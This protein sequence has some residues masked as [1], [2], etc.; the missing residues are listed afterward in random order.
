MN[1][2]QTRPAVLSGG[3]RNGCASLWIPPFGEYG[4][5]A[6]AQVRF[7]RTSRPTPAK[8]EPKYTQEVIGCNTVPKFVAPDP[9]VRRKLKVLGVRNGQVRL[10]QF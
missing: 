6:F 8:C 9:L 10:S 4:M 3:F 2:T 7:V 5:G 1:R